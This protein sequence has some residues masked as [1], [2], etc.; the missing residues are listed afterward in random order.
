MNSSI[1]LQLLKLQSESDYGVSP[2]TEVIQVLGSLLMNLLKVLENLLSKEELWFEEFDSSC[3]RTFENH[4]HEG[5]KEKAR[6]IVALV[7][8]VLRSVPVFIGDGFRT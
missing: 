5:E 8:L 1:D 4:K 3:Q 2:L 7:C 6:D